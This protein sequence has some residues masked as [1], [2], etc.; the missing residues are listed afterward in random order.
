MDAILSSMEDAVYEPL[1]SSFTSKPH[2]FLERDTLLRQTLGL[3]L[4]VNLAGYFLYFFAAG[5]SYVFIWDKRFEKHHLFLKNQVSREIGVSSRS[6]L[7]MSFLTMPFFLLEVRGY[8]RLHDELPSAGSLILSIVTFV[9][10][11]D[12]AIYWIH[13]WL[14]APLPYKFLHKTHHT[15]KIPTPFASH[16]F[17]PISMPN[18]NKSF[19]FFQGTDSYKACRIIFTYFSSQ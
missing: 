9:L 14:H 5:M 7:L 17:H 2:P 3:T 16:A 10:F 6:I 12:C 15:W 1:V 19:R 8:S 18:L 13:R 11:T 4:I